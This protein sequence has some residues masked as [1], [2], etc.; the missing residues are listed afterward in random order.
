[1]DNNTAKVYVSIIN[2][3]IEKLE[4]YYRN[5]NPCFSHLYHLSI[6]KIIKFYHDLKGLVR[7][8][9]SKVYKIYTDEQYQASYSNYDIPEKGFI[10]MYKVRNL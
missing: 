3:R 4:Q 8:F 10:D 1:M 5:N 6:E 2:N 9:T 7:A